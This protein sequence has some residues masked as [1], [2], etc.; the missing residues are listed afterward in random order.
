MFMTAL[1]QGDPGWLGRAQA[2]LS[3][4][5]SSRELP[6]ES[7]FVRALI[8]QG[9][10]DF[11]AARLD[12][13]AAIAQDS[14]RAEFWSW[15]FAVDLVGSRLP[16]A[17]ASCDQLRRLFGAAEG[18][19]CLGLL[20]LRSGQPRQGQQLLDRL[21]K[22]AGDPSSASSQWLAFHRGEAYRMLGQPQTARAIWQEA[23][24]AAEKAGDRAHGL[25]LALVELLND[26]GLHAEALRFNGLLPRS[27]ALLV[28][29]IRSAKGLGR[30]EEARD[31]TKAF[32]ERLARQRARGD[33]S[34]E[35][36]VVVFWLDVEGRPTEALALARQAW[37]TQREPADAVLL[38][39]AAL[40]T[41]HRASAEEVVAWVDQTGLVDRPS[42][43]LFRDLRA[44][45]SGRRP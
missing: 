40:A 33:L 17:R 41:G 6:A 14:T 24:R 9:L 16:E 32:E 28:Q 30:L 5:W 42:E 11:Q 4:W 13:K 15:L 3:P 25:R 29:A 31:L 18:D 8:R 23:L 7:L 39:R 10:H 20:H 36:P 21:A 43:G 1:D 44:L 37:A 45:A 26:Q 2:V 38:G 34:N 19:A 27:D 22:A 35:R 12:L